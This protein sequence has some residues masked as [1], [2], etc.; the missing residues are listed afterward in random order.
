MK[1][2]PNIGP[3]TR[4]TYVVTGVVL[5]AAGVFAP[6]SSRTLAWV[7]GLLGIVPLI[8]GAIGF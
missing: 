4:I 1:L 7:V 2:I 5:I 8:E 6:F 3:M